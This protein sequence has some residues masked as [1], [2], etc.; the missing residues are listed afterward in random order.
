MATFL[1]NQRKKSEPTVKP[2]VNGSTNVEPQRSSKTPDVQNK[3]V[4]ED[5]EE[6]NITEYEVLS[7]KSYNFGNEAITLYRLVPLRKQ[8]L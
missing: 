8:F 7:T 6:N 1:R 2:V 3:I 5:K 4:R